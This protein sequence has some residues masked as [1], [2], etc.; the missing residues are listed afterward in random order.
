MT[1][2]GFA[3]RRNFCLKFMKAC[4]T[5]NNRNQ[6]QKLSSKMKRSVDHLTQYVRAT[7]GGAGS[8]RTGSHSTCV[9]APAAT[10]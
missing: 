5:I 3:D 7:P 2:H 8:E 6:S 9:F 4:A 1:R 10:G